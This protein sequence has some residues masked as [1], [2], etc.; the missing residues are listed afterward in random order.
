MDFMHRPELRTLSSAADFL[1]LFFYWFVFESLSLSAKAAA[2][3]NYTH[4][5]L[6]RN[7]MGALASRSVSSHR[8][9]LTK[10]REDSEESVSQRECS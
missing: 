7:V 6:L 3:F 1:Y 10:Q 4:C 8:A 5:L 2:Q 9:Q